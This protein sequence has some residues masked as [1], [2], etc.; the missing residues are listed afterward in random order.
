VNEGYPPHWRHAVIHW[1]PLTDELHSDGDHTVRTWIESLLREVK[2]PTRQWRPW[3]CWLM[4]LV[5]F[6][7]WGCECDYRAP[8]GRVIEAGC[9]KHD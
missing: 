6:R 1:N 7:Y 9:A 2:H 4:N 3:E 5:D 8:Y